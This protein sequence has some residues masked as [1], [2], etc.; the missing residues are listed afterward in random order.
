[1]SAAKSFEEDLELTRKVIATFMDGT[2]G[3]EPAAVEEE[4]P[5]GDEEE[6]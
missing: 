4:P 5:A 1:M 3:V 6:E 2:N